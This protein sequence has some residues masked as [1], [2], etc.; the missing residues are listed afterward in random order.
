M[1]AR[2]HRWVAAVVAI[3]LADDC[4]ARLE[5]REAAGRQRRAAGGELKERLAL[6]AGHG[7]QDVD[8]SLKS[9]AATQQYK[10]MLNTSDFISHLQQRTIPNNNKTTKNPV[11]S[12][13]K[14][15]ICRNN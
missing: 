5:V 11:L 7:H 13:G 8:E 10:N 12:R 1:D 14:T 3:D 4:Q 6:V 2:V 9:G 15:I